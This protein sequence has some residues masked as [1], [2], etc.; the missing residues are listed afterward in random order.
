[1][2]L[3]L[4]ELTDYL[5]DLRK[6]YGSWEKTADALGI[7]RAYFHRLGTGQQACFLQPKTLEKL[8][9]GIAFVV[10]DDKR[11]SSGEEGPPVERKTFR[12]SPQQPSSPSPTTWNW[13]WR[14]A[15][16]QESDTPPGVAEP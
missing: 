2:N 10:L 16:Q 15:Q 12:E 3:T 13:P 5:A 8:G 7:S 11:K 9:L 14:Q 1:M 6:R 4:V